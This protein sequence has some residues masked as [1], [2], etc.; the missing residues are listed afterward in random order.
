FAIENSVSVD[1][2]I[3]PFPKVITDPLAEEF[4]LLGYGV[5]TVT[6]LRMKVYGLGIYISKKDV[7][8]VPKILDSKFLSSFYENLEDPNL[9]T[10]LIDN[11]LASGIK[12]TARIVPLRNTDFNHLRD[13]LVKSIMASPKAKEAL[14]QENSPLPEGIDDL[15]KVFG[16]KHG[17]CPKGQSLYLEL[18]EDQTLAVKYQFKDKNSR[19]VETTLL[20]IVKEP[21]VG[22]MLFLQYLSG[23]N[24]LSNETKTKSVE[25][26]ASL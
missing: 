10:I 3:P 12:F 9:S 8:N 24:P 22:K 23:K 20:G 14:Q 26:L 16:N 18:L 15:R 21:L 17:S 13:G 6:F 4:Q 25:S 19:K 2:S 7:A 5:R 1:K 11:L